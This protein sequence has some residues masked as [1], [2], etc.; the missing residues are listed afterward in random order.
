MLIACLHTAGSNAALFDAALRAL[1]APGAR[2]AHHVQPDLLA[3]AEAAGGLTPALSAR[4]AAA[5]RGLALHAG[6][7]LLTCST[8][9]PAA[10]DAHGAAL[11]APL[12]IVPHPTS[13]VPIL[14]VDAALAQEAVRHGGSVVVLCTAPTTLDPTRCL[15]ENAARATG[16]SVRVQLVPGAW[17][18]FHAGE[19]AC[20]H[21]LVAEAAD[22]AAGTGAV[23]ALAQASM[24][25]AAALAR[26]TPLTSPA[27]GLH[28]ALQAAALT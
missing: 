27:A 20:Y 19:A 11:A 7:V 5:L 28:A 9:G 15:F 13:R 1:G 8:L 10:G 23:V 24:A 4:T 14:R 22:A 6:A 16:A 2:L 26:R 12:P 17:A 25:P 18:A 3:E 21:V